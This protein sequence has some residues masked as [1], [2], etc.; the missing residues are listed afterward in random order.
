MKSYDDEILEETIQFLETYEEMILKALAD[1][2]E[3]DYN[4]IED[5]DQAFNEEI[6]PSFTAED[7]LYIMEECHNPGDAEFGSDANEALVYQAVESYKND[8]WFKLKA[9]YE[10]MQGRLDDITPVEGQTVEKTAF[11]EIVRENTSLAPLPVKKD[12][13]EE[14]DLLREWLSLNDRAGGFWAGCP[15]GQS[16][17]D[18]RCGSGHRMPD[19]KDFVDFDHEVREKVPWLAGKYRRDVQARFDELIEKTRITHKMNYT[20]LNKIEKALPNVIIDYIMT[21]N[22]LSISDIREIAGVLQYRAQGWPS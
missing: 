3:W 16:Y 19:I 18:A 12:S 1:I 9:I 13:K 2:A 20:G 10:D 17:I 6:E 15:L 4:D 11:D 14:L 8:V 5:L 7:A 22:R 21:D